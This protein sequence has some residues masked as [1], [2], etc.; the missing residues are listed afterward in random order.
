MNHKN[1]LDSYHVSEEDCHELFNQIIKYLNSKNVIVSFIN[2][3]QD[4]NTSGYEKKKSLK[5][6]DKHIITTVSNGGEVFMCTD[7][8]YVGGIGSRLFDIL[9]VGCGHIWQWSASE[10]SGL[11]FYG[12]YSWEIATKFYLNANEEELKLVWRYERE[13]GILAIQNLKN[14]L[15][16]CHFNDVFKNNILRYL[17]DYTN[18]DLKYISDF[19]KTGIVKGLLS[20]WQFD[21]EALPEIQINFPL[22]VISRSNTT[23]PLIK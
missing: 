14:I 2:I 22:N 7:I 4:L 12:F 20:Q 10:E 21:S 5:N 6:E 18:S 23:I 13:A 1:L 17:T 16:T 8:D 9:H 19:Y 11:E 3:E 15:E